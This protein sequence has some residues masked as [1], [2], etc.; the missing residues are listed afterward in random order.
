MTPI[1]PLPRPASQHMT[2]T[3]PSSKCRATRCL[4]A[5][6]LTFAP[7]CVS[8]EGFY[9]ALRGLSVHPSDAEGS[10]VDGP[11]RLNGEFGLERGFGVAAAIGYETDSGWQ[12][13]AEVG[14]RGVGIDGVR[15]DSGASAFFPGVDTVSVAADGDV[16]SKSLMLNA[17]YTFDAPSLR[18]YLGAGL[19]LARHSAKLH[20]VEGFPLINV[21]KRD[22]AR[23]YQLMAGIRHALTEDA[24]L[25]IG[26]RLFATDDPELG[27]VTANYLTHDIEIGVG[28]AF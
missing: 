5:A 11:V 21:E 20:G 10:Y 12:L 15:I 1:A 24:E 9:G 25:R 26:Y 17:Y 3:T 27:P 7:L 16:R 19:G 22:T 23:A 14:H 13:E 8:A 28:F 18:P 4:I 6:M 2:R